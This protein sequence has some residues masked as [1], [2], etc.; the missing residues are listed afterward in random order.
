MSK[1]YDGVFYDQG[2]ECQYEPDATEILCT[3]CDKPTG[4]RGTC[5]D[6]GL[7]QSC[8]KDFE[9][10]VG[11]EEVAELVIA[12]A[13]GE[14]YYK[15]IR[16]AMHLRRGDGQ[17]ICREFANKQP[18]TTNPAEVSCKRCLKLAATTAKGERP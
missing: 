15:P 13:S 5:T 9:Y 11:E 3:E 7:C 14:H 10:L 18:V 16:R 4:E 8:R 6:R 1:F 17:P 2:S 12:Q